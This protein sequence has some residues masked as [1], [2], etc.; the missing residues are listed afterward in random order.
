[1]KNI[2]KSLNKAILQSLTGKYSLYVFQLIS[3]AILSRIFTPEMFGTIATFQVFILFFQLLATSGLAPAIIYQDKFE[4]VERDGVFSVTVMIGFIGALLFFVLTP[5]ISLWLNLSGVDVLSWVLAINIFFS[6]LSMLPMAALQKDAK[7]LL[8][9]KAEI[10]AE[11]ISLSICITLYSLGYGIEAL[12]SKLLFVPVFRFVFYYINSS[13]T[14]IGQP[15]LG[16]HLSAIYQLMAVAKYQLG[17]NVLN[18]FSRNLDTI[19]I[20]KYFG[21]ATV[22]MYE[23]SYQIMRYPLQLF[24]FAITPALQPILTKYKHDPEL[25]EKEFYRV[26]FKLAALGFFTAMVLFWSTYDVVYIMFGPQWQQAADI[27]RI[28]TITIPL[29]MV[30]SSTGGVYQ[31]F[32]ATKQLLSCGIFSSF[33]NVTAI[34]LGIYSGDIKLL[35][36]FL[37]ASFALNYFQC[38]YLLHK[39]I[40]KCYS[41]K[42]IVLL[43]I[44]IFSVYLN[45]FFID[46][47]VFHHASLVNAFVSCAAISLIVLC[48]QAFLYFFIKRQTYSLF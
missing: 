1:V 18:F 15:K 35:C 32:G 5:F 25:V 9:A 3:L 13:D 23:K 40:F 42:K 36:L 48:F 31:A 14:V 17:F 45:L 10:V 11:L 16:K 34:V 6:S 21:V 19:L 28:L 44:M 33:T 12:A 22:G 24:T 47:D 2:S 38:F 43:S 37:S 41:I 20:T 39:G 30:L 7:F 46:V 29:Q 4:Q 26:A 8:I 27:L